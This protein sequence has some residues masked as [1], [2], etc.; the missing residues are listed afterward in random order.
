MSESLRALVAEDRPKISHP[1]RHGERMLGRAELAPTIPGRIIVADSKQIPFL[2]KLWDDPSSKVREAVAAEFLEFGDELA[3]KLDQWTE[4]L[5]P[6]RRRALEAMIDSHREHASS[7]PRDAIFRPGQLMR[8]RR[9]GYRGVV[10]NLDRRCEAD[11]AWYYSNSSQPPREQPWYHVLVD[12]SDHI[13]YVAQTN[14]LPDTS[15]REVEH[16][17]VS[18]FFSG[19]D[20]KRYARNDRPWPSG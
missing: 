19:F 8:H 14:V 17:L 18:Q 20:G 16:P 2:L 15:G 3:A 6:E 12:G 4:L 1:S 10:V 7:A 13:T 11:D 9:H 5:D